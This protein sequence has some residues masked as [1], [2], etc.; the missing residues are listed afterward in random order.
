MII[1]QESLSLSKGSR[2][3]DHPLRMLRPLALL[4]GIRG[5]YGNVAAPTPC[6]L[7]TPSF[8]ESC[9]N[10]REDTRKNFAAEINSSKAQIFYL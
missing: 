1:C 7:T 9:A 6:F 4:P 5:C 8:C 2:R 10:I 3:F